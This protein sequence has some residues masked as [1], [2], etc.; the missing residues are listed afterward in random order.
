MPSSDQQSRQYQS[1]ARLVLVQEIRSLL[2]SP[3]LWTMLIIVSV[4]VGYSFME[5]V[6][7]FSQASRTA[8]KYPELAAGMSPLAGIFVP[9]FGAYYLSQTLLLPFIAIRSIGLDKYNGTLKLLMQL[10]LSPLKLCGVKLC[11]MTLVWIASL[12]P[13]SLAL[14]LWQTAGGHI[15]WPELLCLLA[16]HGLYSL[17]IITLAMFAATVSDSLPTA[18]MFCLAVTLGSWVLD[19]A[20][21]G[22]TDLIAFLGNF[23]FTAMLR[24]FENG[25]FT[26]TYVI[27]FLSVTFFFFF[28]TVVWLPPGRAV[29]Q[30]IILSLACVAGFVLINLG[31][32]QAP[33]YVDLTENKNHSFAKGYVKA[34]RQLQHPL[35]ITVNLDPQDSRLLDLQQ[36]VLGKLQRTVPDLRILYKNEGESGLFSKEKNE[37]YGLILY[38]YENR[39]D[40]SYS[41]SQEEIL[42]LI[43]NLAGIQYVQ[44]KN[45]EP[46]GYPLVTEI[47]SG[48]ILFYCFL[49]LFFLGSAVFVRTKMF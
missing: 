49:P 6:S 27:S 39:K 19:F 48:K 36:D 38:S 4:L 47:D 23:S 44:Q 37:D 43:F 46:H 22:K 34:L 45:Q 5:A 7:L 21:S 35:T 11:A 13:A 28:L 8:L 24:Q 42:P 29:R 15:Y 16:G 10:P 33:K 2:L 31:A 1:T 18:A 40:K 17:T 14:V 12:I 25:L 32:Q 41:N 20:A 9:T 26:S 3:A 30:K